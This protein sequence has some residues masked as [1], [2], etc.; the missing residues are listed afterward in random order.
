MYRRA[1]A[2]SIYRMFY[3]HP[4]R[5]QAPS[6]QQARITAAP[7][8]VIKSLLSVGDPDHGRPGRRPTVCLC[9]ACAG[10]GRPLLPRTGSTATGSARAVITFPASRYGGCRGPAIR[11]TSDGGRHAGLH[12]LRVMAEVACCCR[13]LSWLGTRVPTRRHRALAR[14]THRVAVRW[15]QDGWRPLRIDSGCLSAVPSPGARGR[16]AA[17]ANNVRLVAD[18]ACFA[19]AATHSLAGRC[20]PRCGEYATVTAGP[21]AHGGTRNDHSKSV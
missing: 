4:T 21:R 11:T 9:I 16:M 10:C 14:D 20:C 12:R 6:D 3:L 17:D 18:V 7:C 1:L 13:R 15:Y 5:P 19:A 8:A 2:G